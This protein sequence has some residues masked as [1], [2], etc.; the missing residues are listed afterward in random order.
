MKL[1]FTSSTALPPRHISPASL[2]AEGLLVAH[3]ARPLLVS[4]SSSLG[5]VPRILPSSCAMCHPSV[6]MR[7]RDQ[8]GRP[9]ECDRATCCAS[10]FLPLSFSFS[11]THPLRLSLP[12]PP[13]TPE[14]STPGSLILNCAPASGVAS[15]TANKTSE[16]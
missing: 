8:P 5:P 14:L 6:L 7:G 15:M 10:T 2:S 3:F 9:L 12:L 4:L 11:Y 1:C 16:M 13:Q